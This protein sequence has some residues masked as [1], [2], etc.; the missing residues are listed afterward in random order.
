MDNIRLYDTK[1]SKERVAHP[2]SYGAEGYVNFIKRGSSEKIPFQRV[3][4]LTGS[5][6]YSFKVDEMSNYQDISSVI[7]NSSTNIV[8]LDSSFPTFYR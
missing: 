8:V 1:K 4:A 7:P 2:I 3:F 6:K 5:I